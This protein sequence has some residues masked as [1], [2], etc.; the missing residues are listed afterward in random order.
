MKLGIIMLLAVLVGV[1]FAGISVSNYTISKSTYQPGDVGIA[2]ITVTNPVGTPRVSGLTMTIYNP[3]EVSV[4]GS[5]TLS[6]IES[7]G[8]AVVS[9]PF[10][11][12]QDAKPGIYLIN[13]AFTGFSQQQGSTTQTSTTNTVPLPIIVVHSPILSIAANKPV[14]GGI[15]SVV[16]TVTNKGGAAKDLRIS[17][18][19]SV[20]LYG[21]DQ[22]YVGNLTDM[23]NVNVT[24]DARN[25]PDGPLDVPFVFTYN[26]ELG[27]PHVDTT[28][29]RITIKNEVLDLRFNQLTPLITGKDG[30]LK[31]QVVN[32]GGDLSDVRISFINSSVR[33]KDLSEIKLGDLAAGQSVT[34]TAL[35][36]NDLTPGVN[37]VDSKITWTDRDI[38]KEQDMSIPV[39]IDSD[40]DVGVYLEAKPS[41][42]E[43]GQETT[44]SVLVS[45][46]GSY[47][48]D[49]VDVGLGSPDFQSLDVTPRQY[50]GSLAKDDFS[51]VQFKVLP[52][53]AGEYPI[54][55]NVMYRDASGDWVNKTITQ[56]GNVTSPPSGEGGTIYILLGIVVI[57]AAA[58]WF[59]K[60]RKKAGSGSA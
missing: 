47:G 36:H 34:V 44:I 58:L 2:T 49:N 1:S 14:I 43:V 54:N 20:G 3:K 16:L 5:S 8:M 59:F 52:K 37:L 33:L 18:S 48:I 50:I 32:N 29:L 53:S 21:T 6:D 51:T 60:F 42:L 15:D 55:V 45:N 26:D 12:S 4:T 19:G 41:P 27:N 9:I 39:T 11:I 40:A 24:L 46:V 7:G 31:L 25:A 17:T 38:R 10:K 57:V 28:T 35:V 23:A 13:V 22:V 30:S 56:S